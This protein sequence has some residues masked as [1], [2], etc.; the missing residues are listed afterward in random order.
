V[1]LDLLVNKIVTRIQDQQSGQTWHKGDHRFLVGLQH[2]RKSLT[3]AVGLGKGA[4]LYDKRLSILY[5]Q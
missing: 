2:K 1:N 4:V 5:I 3:V